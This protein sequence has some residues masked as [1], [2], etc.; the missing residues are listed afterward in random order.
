MTKTK[1]I[2]LLVLF[3]L[4]ILSCI[5]SFPL[6]FA[7]ASPRLNVTGVTQLAQS[8]EPAFTSLAWSP[9]STRLAATHVEPSSADYPVPLED[10]RMQI[11]ILTIDDQEKNNR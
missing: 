1:S 3:L 11:Q 7:P 6:P 10:N 9:D 8:V 4:L 2:W 5:P